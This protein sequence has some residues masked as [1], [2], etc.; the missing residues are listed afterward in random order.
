LASRHGEC[1]RGSLGG[2]EDDAPKL[3]RANSARKLCAVVDGFN[4]EATT[5]MEQGDREALERTCRYQLRGPLALDRLKIDEETETIRYELK[6]PD[7]RGKDAPGDDATAAAGAND[8]A[9]SL[10]TALLAV[11]VR[12]VGE[13]I[14]LEKA[15]GSQE[16]ATQPRP[17]ASP[18]RRETK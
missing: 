14:S 9:D 13:W 4:L 7:R 3:T 12:R 15:R 11:E 17:R 18:A 10:A 16:H 8:R 1:A 2:D 6:H 5:T